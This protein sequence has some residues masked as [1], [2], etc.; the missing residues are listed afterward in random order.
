M[1]S[2]GGRLREAVTYDRKCHRGSQVWV[3][4]IWWFQAF[5]CLFRGS[6]LVA[7]TM[8]FTSAAMIWAIRYSNTFSN[9]CPGEIQQIMCQAVVFGR[10]KT[11]ENFK[12][13]PSRVVAV[14][15]ERWCSLTKGSIY[16][17]FT[18]NFRIFWKCGCLWKVIAYNRWKVRLHTHL[19][20]PRLRHAL[21]TLLI[22][23]FGFPLKQ[24]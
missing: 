8:R 18:W 13:S 17:D 9:F 20:C 5:I 14:A 15:Y 3:V 16:S 22:I 4:C 21:T 19:F 6:L 11:L 12:Q 7:L 1:S 2:L 24:S 10:L 23:A